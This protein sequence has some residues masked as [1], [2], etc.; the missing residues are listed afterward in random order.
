MRYFIA[1][2]GCDKNTVD[3]EQISGLLLRG[4]Y[5]R[6]D[7][8]ADAD[9]VLINTC[10]FIDPAKEESIEA[11]LGF[12][13]ARKNGDGDYKIAVL[14]CLPEL[15]MDEV[16]EAIPEFDI[17]VRPSEYNN[18]YDI[19][20]GNARPNPRGEKGYT[21]P[22]T[23]RDPLGP[24]YS[25]FIK[26]SDGCDLACSYCTIPLIRGPQRSRAI[27]DIRGELARLTAEGGLKE[28]IAVSQNTSFYGHD[29]NSDVNELLDLFGEFTVPW[30]R[31][32][33]LDIRKIDARFLDSVERNNILP[34]FDI[35]LQHVDDEVLA[36]MKRGY[37]LD[38]IREKIGLI[39]R[40][41]KEPVIRTTFI[42]GYPAETERSFEK[43][44]DFVRSERLDHVGVFM[45]SPQEKSAS[46]SLGDMVPDQVKEER[47]D[48][49]MNIQ[50]E[51]RTDDLQSYVGREFDLLTDVSGEDARPWFFAPEVDG[52]VF[53][54][55]KGAL[56]GEFHRARIT[57]SY[58]YDLEGEILYETH[59]EYFDDY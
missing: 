13:E 52:S 25:R 16:T 50:K 21:G 43:L 59:P 6:S 20:A 45:Y 42:V 36:S 34:Y 31:L 56:Q 4:G 38:A 24:S 49:L 32:L 54:D 11:I 37:G 39:R 46:A 9:V 30:K 28:I 40:R 2:L 33:Y 8:A 14:G 15:Y 5:E 17:W 51:I 29:I 48:L 23:S 58:E 41:F 19:I 44:A 47:L 26:V 7:D 12:A 3:S 10:S 1:T 18:I 27:A 57:G 35:P 55:D 53:I 22:Y